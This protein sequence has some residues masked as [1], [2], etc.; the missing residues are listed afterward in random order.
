M[1]TEVGLAAEVK[2]EPEK[3][4]AAATER[5]KEAAENRQNPPSEPSEEPGLPPPAADSPGRPRQK[6]EGEPSESRGLAR[7]LPP[8]LKK[9]KSYT[10]VAAGDKEPKEPPRAV[11]EQVAGPEESSPEGERPHQAEAQERAGSRQQEV[12]AGVKDEKPEKPA[13]SPEAQVCLRPNLR[14]SAAW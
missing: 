13:A 1:T 11:V 14:A 8:W 6:R 7:F 2:Q 9:Q 4:G 3:V 10:L 12:T 5:P